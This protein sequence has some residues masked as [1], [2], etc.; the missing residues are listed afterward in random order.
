[1]ENNSK[2]LQNNIFK[3]IDQINNQIHY[4]KQQINKLIRYQHLFLTITRDKRFLRFYHNQKLKAFVLH[5]LMSLQI[6]KSKEME[7]KNKHRLSAMAR[8]WHAWKDEMW[9]QARIQNIQKSTAYPNFILRQIV[10]RLQQEN[11][12]SDF[13]QQANFLQE[14]ITE[15]DEEVATE[16]KR[17]ALSGQS[18]DDCF[19]KPSC[20]P[21]INQ[22]HKFLEFCIDLNQN[23]KTYVVEVIKFK[24]NSID[25]L[26]NSILKKIYKNNT[27]DVNF[28]TLEQIFTKLD[29]LKAMWPSI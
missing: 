1:M 12:Q 25:I 20:K 10:S 9:E 15:F 27:E 23:S 21:L 17:F 6:L 11:K 16:R 18:Y 7:L 22:L 26:V 14:K 8:A 28:E 13:R 4:Q 29:Q 3:V 2:L 24:Y 19:W 5:T